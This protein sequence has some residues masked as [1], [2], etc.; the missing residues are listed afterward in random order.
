MF[1][2]DD[3]AFP[4]TIMVDSAGGPLLRFSGG[5]EINIWNN[6][7]G[8]QWGPAGSYGFQ[9]V[10]NGKPYGISYWNTFHEPICTCLRGGFV[11]GRRGWFAWI[12]LFWPLLFAKVKTGLRHLVKNKWAE[13]EQKQKGIL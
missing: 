9:E 6:G 13:V 2:Y 11:C 8:S 1:V 4:S 10:I 3:L 7:S 5:T 12:G